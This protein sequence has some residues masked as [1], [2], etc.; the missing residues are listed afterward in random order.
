MGQTGRGDEVLHIALL[1]LVVLLVVGLV[2][3]GRSGPPNARDISWLVG[4]GVVPDDEAA[5]V[6]RYLGRHRRHRMVGG[7]VGVVAAGIASMRLAD[8]ASLQVLLFGGIAG[9]LVGT[10]S[11]ESY[12]LRPLAPGATTVASLEPRDPA[13]SAGVVWTARGL[14]V[15]AALGAVA[16]AAWRHDAGPLWLVGGGAVVT[17]FAEATRARI[18]GRRRPV[19]SFRARELDV[20]IRAFAGR[21]VAWLQLAATVL[22]VGGVVGAIPVTPA[23]L[24]VLRALALL[25]ALVEAIVF[26]HRAAPRPPV[27]WRRPA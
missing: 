23:P 6:R 21:S 5:V 2:T 3:L 18:V 1:L 11:A 17:A 15:A 7:L 20:R 16:T 24:G 8:E 26:T 12:R 10:L 9:V 19:L 4:A 25:A 13:P 22:V 14:L 27:S